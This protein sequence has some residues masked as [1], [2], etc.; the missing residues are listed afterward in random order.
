MRKQYFWVVCWLGIFA[1]SYA[2]KA[3]N[4]EDYFKRLQ[5]SDWQK[6]VQ[7]KAILV[8]DLKN[9]YMEYKN[10]FEEP[11]LTI[12]LQQY[13]TRLR[14]DMVLVARSGCKGDVCVQ[15]G[16]TVYNVSHANPYQEIAEEVLPMQALRNFYER[17]S[18]PFF[19]LP[20]KPLEPIKI[21]IHDLTPMY[22]TQKP[23]NTKRLVGEL[24]YNHKKEVFEL[25]ETPQN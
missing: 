11:V 23:Q 19:E 17:Y 24:R 3:L 22:R 6:L 7:E 8:K 12:A 20:K 2:Q 25:V 16:F 1:Q 21:Y 18:Y 4:I 13:S 9:G 10:I 5:G 14:P 15:V